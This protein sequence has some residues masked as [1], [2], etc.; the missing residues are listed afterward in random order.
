MICLIQLVGETK[1]LWLNYVLQSLKQINVFVYS[2]DF[3]W[4]KHKNGI[5][6]VKII[7]LLLLKV[8]IHIFL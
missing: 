1:M 7:F 8:I 5:V 4:L 3:E 2:L 6:E